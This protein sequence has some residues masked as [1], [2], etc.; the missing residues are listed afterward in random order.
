MLDAPSSWSTNLAT[1]KQFSDSSDEERIGVLFVECHT[2]K[3]GAV[4]VRALSHFSSE[5][6]CLYSGNQKWR[7]MAARS[8]VDYDEFEDRYQTKIV[9]E[10][11]ESNHPTKVK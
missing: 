4:S 11:A 8:V 9:I 1:S 10:V 3:K 7:V 2:P 6:E 5:K